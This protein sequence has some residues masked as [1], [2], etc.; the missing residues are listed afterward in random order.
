MEIFEMLK[1][2]ELSLGSIEVRGKENL[3]LLL[4]SIMAV[5]KMISMLDNQKKEE[6]E[7]GR[8]TDI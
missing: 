2:L 6:N 3:D 4:G 8:Q 7:D 1:T 5:E